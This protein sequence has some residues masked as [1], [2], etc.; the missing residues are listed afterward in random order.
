MVSP[1][2]PCIYWIFHLEFV[3][4]TKLPLFHTYPHVGEFFINISFF[5]KKY[6]YIYTCMCAW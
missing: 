1:R 3:K 2:K 4:V 5:M 6:L